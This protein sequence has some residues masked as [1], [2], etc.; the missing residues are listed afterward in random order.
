MD[1][2]KFKVPAKIV[3]SI[4][5]IM[6]S[7]LAYAFSN[8][9]S[10]AEAQKDAEISQVQ[11]NDVKF[12]VDRVES[13]VDALLLNQGIRWHPRSRTTKSENR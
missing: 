3:L 1:I 8:F 12:S 2:E 6:A 4:G 5:G 9:Q 13:K 7:I 11:I 10:K